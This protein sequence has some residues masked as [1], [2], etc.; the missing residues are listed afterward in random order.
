MA[1]YK[2]QSRY[3]RD[4][5]HCHY[6]CLWE[7]TPEEVVGI[8]S[9]DDLRNERNWFEEIVMPTIIAH[10]ESQESRRVADNDAPVAEDNGGGDIDRL[11]DS[12]GSDDTE[13][14][15]TERN[16]RLSESN[17]SDERVLNENWTWQLM[18]MYEDLRLD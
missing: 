5:W 12:D 8:W 15:D 9:W 13:D 11:S 1:Y 10:G 18:K 6:L 14:D 2:V 16:G 17:D 7:V 4:Y 3:G